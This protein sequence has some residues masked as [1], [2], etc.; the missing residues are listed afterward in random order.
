M[1]TQK[2]KPTRPVPRVME[3]HPT[4]IATQNEPAPRVG[5]CKLKPTRPLKIG[6]FGHFGTVNTGNESTLLAIL[7][8]LRARPPRERALLYLHQTRRRRRERRDRCDSD[9]DQN[10]QDLGS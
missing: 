8:H 7:S 3:H 10:C 9:H 6:L 2:M 5:D 4:A 1:P